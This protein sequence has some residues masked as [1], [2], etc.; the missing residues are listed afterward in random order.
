MQPVPV[1]DFSQTT[2]LIEQGY[3]LTLSEIQNRLQKQAPRW[4]G[5]VSRWLRSRS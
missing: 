5:W 3:Q 1:W 2:E 4:R